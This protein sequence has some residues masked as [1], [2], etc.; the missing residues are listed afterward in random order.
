MISI[1]IIIACYNGEKFI[2]Q[3]FESILH[4]AYTNYEVILIDDHST[5]G[6]HKLYKKYENNRKIRILYSDR[7]RG[8]AQSNNIGA[9]AAKGS[10]LFF[11]NVDTEID[12]K[13]LSTIDTFFKTNTDVGAAQP[14]L[15]RAFT[16]KIDSVGHFLSPV[17]LPYEIGT[18]ED[19]EKYK[20]ELQIFGGKNAAL[21]VR[22]E[23][24]TKVG[25]FDSDYVIYGEDTD[26]CWRI[27]LIG[28]RVVF[29]PDADVYHF[30]R[31]SVNAKTKYRIYYEGSK[32]NINYVIKNAA[33][34][35]ILPMLTLNIATWFLIS[36]KL[37][38]ERRADLSIWVWKGI[39]WNIIHIGKTL[40]KRRVISAF[41]IKRDLGKIMYGSLT[42]YGLITRGLKWLGK[43]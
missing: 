28:K 15:I 18:G 14:K 9:N 31:S 26:L 12:K 38:I 36:I 20:D 29:L 17:G 21:V 33:F 13:C 41:A 39:G 42:V 11:L 2:T 30:E 16:K 7:N 4:S 22:K 6:S 25:G 3:C 35:K 27:W 8:L 19:P 32:N 43:V 1:S 23:V 37:L 24:F 10:L 40:S 5:D 34:P